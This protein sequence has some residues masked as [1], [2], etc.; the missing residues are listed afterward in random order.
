MSENKRVSY[1][2]YINFNRIVNYKGLEVVGL[3]VGLLLRAFGEDGKEI[4]IL[5]KT[6]A[7]YMSEAADCFC[8]TAAPSNRDIVVCLNSDAALMG[9]YLHG[10]EVANVDAT[11]YEFNLLV[12]DD[13]RKDD[14]AERQQLM[15]FLKDYHVDMSYCLKPENPF[16]CSAK[17]TVSEQEAYDLYDANRDAIRSPGIPA[18]SDAFALVE[19]VDDTGLEFLSLA[20]KDDTAVLAYTRDGAKLVSVWD[21]YKL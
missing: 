3:E 20:T 11:I 21:I 15:Q 12:V 1:S 5:D 16:Y 6:D 19:D 7:K 8:V 2:Y 10:Q 14:D 17:D 18:S 4:P 9:L 13:S